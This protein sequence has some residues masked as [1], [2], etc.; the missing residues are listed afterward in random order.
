MGDWGE[1]SCRSHN[2][3]NMNIAWFNINY[4]QLLTVKIHCRQKREKK[5]LW[6]DRFSYMSFKL[7]MSLTIFLSYGDLRRTGVLSTDSLK[8]ALSSTVSM[9]RSCDRTSCV[10]NA[11]LPWNINTLPLQITETDTDGSVHKL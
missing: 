9:L 2:W 3:A 8:V 10:S 6:I 11:L 7:N 5:H 4:H 1:G